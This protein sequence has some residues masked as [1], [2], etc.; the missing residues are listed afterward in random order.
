MGEM[1]ESFDRAVKNHEYGKALRIL[2]HRVWKLERKI[3][4][5]L[6]AL[7]LEETQ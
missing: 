5:V 3:Q 7:H 2:E 1:K 4:S 6:E